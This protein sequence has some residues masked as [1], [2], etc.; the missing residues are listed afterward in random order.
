MWGNCRIF[1]ITCMCRV[2][3][4]LPYPKITPQTGSLW[5]K[6]LLWGLWPQWLTGRVLLCCLSGS[7][8]AP[9][10]ELAWI[11]DLANVLQGLHI[12]FSLN[13][14]HMVNFLF[15]Y[16]SLTDGHAVGISWKRPIFIKIFLE[17]N[18]IWQCRLLKL[19][20]QCC[21]ECCVWSGWRFSP[22]SLG[23]WTTRLSNLTFPNVICV[24]ECVCV[25]CVH[26]RVYHSVLVGVRLGG[27][28]YSPPCLRQSYFS[29][30]R[31]G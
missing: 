13:H 9:Q 7:W 21:V 2:N 25:W 23:V 8:L 22:Y 26:T 20:S 5:R 19:T 4:V 6:V 16:G 14:S 11:L 28:P 24:Y 12:F 18:F 29:L 17:E 31:P 30:H 1:L 15:C 10:K 3:I 27:S